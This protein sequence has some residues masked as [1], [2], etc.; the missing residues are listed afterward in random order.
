M[1]PWFELGI[2]CTEA[3]V[4]AAT[5]RQLKSPWRNIYIHLTAVRNS[6]YAAVKCQVNSAPAPARPA[7]CATMFGGLSRAGRGSTLVDFSALS[8]R[9][10]RAKVIKRRRSSIMP[11]VGPANNWSGPRRRPRRL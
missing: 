5:L 9:G 1:H 8:A 10:R 4:I 7:A 11:S 6:P 2:F 3:Y